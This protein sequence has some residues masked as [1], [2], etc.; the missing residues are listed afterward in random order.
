M[1]VHVRSSL[2]RCTIASSEA[3]SKSNQNKQEKGPIPIGPLT[4]YGGNMSTQTT[5]SR[6]KNILHTKHSQGELQPEASKRETRS[7]LP[8]FGTV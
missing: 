2:F 6:K 5:I 1:N 7:R 8:F 4:F 3:V